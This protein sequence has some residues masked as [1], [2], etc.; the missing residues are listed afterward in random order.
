MGFVRFSESG[1]DIYG[2]H[3]NRV[4]ASTRVVVDYDGLYI[5]AFG[6]T[7]SRDE[8]SS[9]EHNDSEKQVL[10]KTSSGTID[11]RTDSTSY[12]QRFYDAL[13]TLLLMG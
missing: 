10:V 8:I 12:Y 4:F 1:F 7:Y 5:D 13:S 11:I 3:G 2:E 6:K 9:V